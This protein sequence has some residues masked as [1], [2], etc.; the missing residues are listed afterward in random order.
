MRRF[1]AASIVAFAALSSTV[2]AQSGGTVTLSFFLQNLAF[3]NTGSTTMT[4]FQYSHGPAADNTATFDTQG[5]DGFAG[6][7]GSDF[8]SDAR[9][10]Q[11]V[12]W[13]GLSLSAGANAVFGNVDLDLISIL[14]PLSIAPQT[15]TG[16]LQNSFVRAWF[17][18]GAILSASLANGDWVPNQTL[19][20]GRVAVVPEPSTFVLLAAGL[21]GMMALRHRA[22]G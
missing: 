18:D 20:L 9:Y 14:N 8:L 22:R 12:T 11:T 5:N 4:Q 15:T 21:A 6:G 3:T 19:T 7:T 16:G 13:T 17:A 2:N 10:F 1:I